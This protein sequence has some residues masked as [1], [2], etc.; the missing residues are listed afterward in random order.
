MKLA[1]FRRAELVV[2]NGATGKVSEQYAD[3]R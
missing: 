2:E 1:Y 3:E